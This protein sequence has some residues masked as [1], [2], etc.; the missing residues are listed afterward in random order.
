[1]RRTPHRPAGIGWHK[2]L[3]LAALAGP[4][5]VLAGASG[6]HF[7]PLAHGVVI[8]LG[9]LTLMSIL[10][11]AVLVGVLSRYLVD[12]TALRH[13]ISGPGSF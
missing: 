5:F 13:G 3:V 7:G 4:F 8:Q 6:Y 12:V 2:G 10:L 1:M 11:A 9:M